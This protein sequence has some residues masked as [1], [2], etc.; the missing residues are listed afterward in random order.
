[1]ALGG[2]GFAVADAAANDGLDSGDLTGALIRVAWGGGRTVLASDGL[3]APTSVAVGP[4]GD[5]F[6]GSNGLSEDAGEV[7]RFR[8]RPH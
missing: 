8:P 3:V 7:V 1:M 5:V 4:T 2:A 6:I